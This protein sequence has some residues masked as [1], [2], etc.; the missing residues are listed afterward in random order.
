MTSIPFWKAKSL[1][2]LSPEEWESLCDGCG[3][4]CLHKIEDVDTG[5]LFYTSIACRHLDLAQGGCTCYARRAA[6][7]PDCIVLSP[8]S[9]QVV[10]Y[11]PESCAYRCVAEGRDLP[12]WHPLVCGD[13]NMVYT[14]GA[15]IHDW[16]VSEDEVDPDQWLD[17]VLEDYEI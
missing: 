13:R 12:R 8:V 2:E 1:P 14:T 9:L 7:V 17:Y 4:C 11:L 10:D 6:L 16:A 5:E 15:A 3:K